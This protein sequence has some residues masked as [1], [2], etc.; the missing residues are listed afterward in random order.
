MTHTVA[1]I[2]TGIFATQKHL[3]AIAKNKDLEITG[4]FNRTSAKAE[5]FAKEAEKAGAKSL[6][7]YSSIDE[8]LADPNVDSVDALLPVDQNLSIVKKRSRLENRSASRSPLLHLWR[9][10]LRL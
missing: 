3:P 7:I 6:T 9:M 8:L 1:V 2:G 10:A 5:A 4:C